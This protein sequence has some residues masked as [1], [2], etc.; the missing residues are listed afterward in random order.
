MNDRL[1]DFVRKH[2]DQFDPYEPDPSVW[3]K[4]QP[5]G[6]IRRKRTGMR[7]LRVA[8]AVAVI[9]AGSAAG[10]YFLTG[11]H[12]RAEQYGSEL[13]GEVLETEQYYSRMVAERYSELGPYLADDPQTRELL[14]SDMEEL[15]QVYEELKEDLKDNVSNSEVIEAMILNYRM[16]LEILE[17]LLH[18]LKEKEA[19]DD[20]N[21]GSYS[22]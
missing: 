11:G 10:Y 7:W 15:D 21:N 18:Q 5:E 6:G 19:Q 4:I 17:D 13:P 2:R 22:L 16:K 3:L 20:D 12:G 1:E 9:F 8:A 14:R